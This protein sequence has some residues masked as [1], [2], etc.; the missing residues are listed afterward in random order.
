[1]E[2]VVVK[3][4]KQEWRKDMKEQRIIIADYDE[5]VRECLT[6]EIEKEQGMKIVATTGSGMELLNLTQTHKPDLI[7]MDLIL[8]WV[9]GISVLEQ[10]QKQP[11]IFSHPKIL[12]LTK[13]NNEEM[14]QTSFSLGI[15]Y[16]M[17]KPFHGKLVIERIRQISQMTDWVQVHSNKVE[18]LYKK[19]EMQIKEVQQ[20][21]GEQNLEKEVMNKISGMGI[22]HHVKGFRYLETAIV[23][24][25]QDMN[26][27]NGITKDL[28]PTIA[29]KY[30]T[31]PSRVE[32]GIRHAIEVACARSKECG[33]NLTDQEEWF[34]LTGSHRP[35]N[36]EFIAFVADKIR[37]NRISRIR[38]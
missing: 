18:D 8:P 31:T 7:I 34:F 26:R 33:E 27:L 9:D 25:I 28:Y 15:C 32:R 4:D 16:Y 3:Y 21:V 17:L 24:C 36:S 14:M 22:P 10:I 23:L 35:T 12:V 5:R 37:I 1:M 13:L 30:N 19:P 29:K 20:E 2:I 6:S 11:E 38:K